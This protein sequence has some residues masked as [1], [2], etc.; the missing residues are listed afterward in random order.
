MIIKGI[1]IR[2]T[3][4]FRGVSNQQHGHSNGYQRGDSNYYRGAPPRDHQG[5]RG[6][7]GFNQQRNE[8][9]YQPREYQLR[10]SREYKPREYQTR[11]NR[12]YQ[13][14]E[15]R[16]REDRPREDR[17]R[18]DRPREDRPREDRPREDRPRED[19]PREDHRPPVNNMQQQQ[20]DLHPREAVNRRQLEPW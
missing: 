4:V 2:G 16:P 9:G 18:E 8:S 15:D 3:T 14:R 11:D 19:R 13:P 7:G 12:S 20:R 10:D 1:T 17:P 6:G 5:N